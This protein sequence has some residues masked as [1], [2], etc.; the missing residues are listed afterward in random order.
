M[1]TIKLRERMNFMKWNKTLSY[2]IALILSLP[3][4]L[5][6]SINLNTIFAPLNGVDFGS[7]Y[8]VNH[9]FVD[10]VVYLTF[11]MGLTQ[12]VFKP[13]FKKD[14][15]PIIVGVGVAFTFAMCVYELN[16]GFNFSSITPL[17]LIILFLVLCIFLFNVVKAL[18]DDIP[19]AIAV[20]YFIMYAMLLSAFNPLYLWLNK[21]IPIATSLMALIAVIMF[22]VLITRVIKLFSSNGNNTTDNNTTGANTNNN[23]NTRTPTTPTTPPVVPPGINTLVITSPVN[24]SHYQM[25]D[26]PINFTVNGPAFRRNFHYDVRIDGNHYSNNIGHNPHISSQPPIIGSR[27]GAGRHVIEILGMESRGIFGRRGGVAASAVAEFY[28]DGTAYP[29][30]LRNRIAVDLDNAIN[31]L[32]TAYTTYNRFFNTLINLHFNFAH[33]R[34]GRNPTPGE[35]TQLLR[36]RADLITAGNAVNTIVSAIQT[37]PQY[38]NLNTVDVGIFYALLSRRN[39]INIAIIT[40]EILA[41]RNYMAA[42]APPVPPAP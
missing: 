5:A 6:D 10:S 31:T 32:G 15:K 36:H 4:V 40:Y 20:S 13:I 24:G 8:L 21:N 14:S 9:I 35:W 19:T 16:T 3:V 18:F 23:N 33:G 2:I 42:T 12:A 26:I 37:D 41:R 34:G 22:I 30:E 38:A 1:N 27:R 28:I 11:F 25:A 7:F 29:N 17:P 39:R